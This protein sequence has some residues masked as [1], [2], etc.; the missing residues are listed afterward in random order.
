MTLFTSPSDG[1]KPDLAP[2]VKS[3]LFFTRLVFYISQ[4]VR[5]IYHKSTQ[6]HKHKPNET[7]P[8]PTRRR[9]TKWTNN[10]RWWLSRRINRRPMVKFGACSSCHSET[11][12]IRP[13]RRRLRLI[14]RHKVKVILHESKGQMAKLVV[15]RAIPLALLLDLWSLHGVVCASIHL[16]SSIFHVITALSWYLL[17]CLSWY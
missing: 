4:V 12:A 7:Q 11:P 14:S 10:R 1:K 9:F 2:Q 3:P 6:Q 8:P 5:Y 13:Q 15:V 16:I 17:V